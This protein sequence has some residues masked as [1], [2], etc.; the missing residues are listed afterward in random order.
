MLGPGKSDI[1]QPHFLSQ[2]LT[3]LSPL[4]RFRFFKIKGQVSILVKDDTLPGIS[5]RI[6]PTERTKDNL[7]FESFTLVDCHDAHRFF[8]FFEPLF[9]LLGARAIRTLYLLG[10]AFKR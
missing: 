7:I 10:E 9:V 6:A 8:V 4:M 1:K 2:Q 5:F 3:A